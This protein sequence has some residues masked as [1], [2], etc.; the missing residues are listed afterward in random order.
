MFSLMIIIKQINIDFGF[1]DVTL[2]L[3]APTPEI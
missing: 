3:F 1:F 2:N